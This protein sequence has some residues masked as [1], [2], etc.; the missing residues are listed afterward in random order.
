MCGIYGYRARKGVVLTTY[1]STVLS[2]VLAREMESRGRDSWGGVVFEG[3]HAEIYKGLGKVTYSAHQFLR[4]ASNA[5]TILAHTRAATVGKISKDNSHPFLIGD[6]LGVH[7][8]SIYNYEELNKKYNRN[9]EVDS[10]QIFAH[11]NDALDLSEVE[12]HGTFFFS[13]ATELWQNLYVARTMGGS[14]FLARYYRDSD[15]KEPFVTVWAS[16]DRGVKA[17]ADM[18]GAYYSEVE[19]K[20]EKLYKIGEDGEIYDIHEP[21]TLKSR[22]VSSN[23]CW[24]NYTANYWDKH[25]AEPLKENIAT[26]TTGMCFT[27]TCDLGK[28]R[29]NMCDDNRFQHCKSRMSEKCLSAN[30]KACRDCGHCLVD[31]IHNVIDSNVHC[32]T[33]KKVCVVKPVITQVTTYSKNSEKNTSV[34]AVTADAEDAD[35]DDGN[36]I[37]FFNLP[38]KKEQKRLSKRAKKAAKKVWNTETVDPL[39][40]NIRAINSVPKYFTVSARNDQDTIGIPMCL[41]CDCDLDDH[42]WGWCQNSGM[43]KCKSKTK[44]NKCVTNLPLCRDC[45]CHM[46]EGVHTTTPIHDQAIWCLSCNTY[47]ASSVDEPDLDG[48]VQGKGD[49]EATI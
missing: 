47:C 14:L 1:E 28:H 37:N 35:F 10:Q 31:G 42:I 9:F 18:I 24:N 4:A 17:A 11:L 3:E 5:Q 12:G 23:A 32:A 38:S 22:I 34:A 33:C 29:Y 49:E 40:N 20:A 19:I 48:N 39:P 44:A 36:V 7:N 16:E 45:G 6:V 43:S 25:T 46:V 13:K 15:K 21:F 2:T 30:V 26:T 41:E 27:C 8:G